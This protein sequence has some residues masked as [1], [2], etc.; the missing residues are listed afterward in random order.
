MYRRYGLK[1]PRAK[2]PQNRIWSVAFSPDGST[3]ANGSWD[4]TIKVWDVKTGECLRTLRPER[5]YEGMNV[6]GVRGLT[7]AQLASLKVLG[8]VES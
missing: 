1:Q 8:A 4:E 6:T 7:S 2:P 5:P 3:L